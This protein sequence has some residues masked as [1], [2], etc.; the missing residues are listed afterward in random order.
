MNR[1]AEAIEKQ[2]LAIQERLAAGLVTQA[3]VDATQ[4]YLD[5]GLDDYC[6][7]H[8]MK[9]VLAGSTLTHDETQ[10]IYTYLGNT[11]DHFNQQ[12]IEVKAVLTQVMMELM[13]SILTGPQ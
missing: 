7:F 5:I 11:P 1:I 6:L 3:E 2:R 4:K 13:R 8:E 12:P 9:S 10:M